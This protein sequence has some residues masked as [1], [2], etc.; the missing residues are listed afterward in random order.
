MARL[1]NNV[2]NMAKVYRFK[3]DQFVKKNLKIAKHKTI[4]N[5]AI[6]VAKLAKIPFPI[7]G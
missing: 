4:S 1:F 3:H 6:V 5:I 2:P 7:Y